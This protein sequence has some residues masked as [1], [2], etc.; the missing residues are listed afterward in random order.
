MRG[1][2]TTKT[3]DSTIDLGEMNMSTTITL[4][5][6]NSSYALDIPTGPVLGFYMARRGREVPSPATAL[7]AGMDVQADIPAG[8]VV[9][10]FNS[11]NQDGVK[12]VKAGGKLYFEPGDRILVPTGLYADI[13][14]GF[15][16][17]VHSRSGTSWKKGLILTNSVGVVDSDYVQE[18]KISL[19]NNSGV[20]L[21]IEDG[22]RI[23]QLVLKQVCNM[24]IKKLNQPPNRKTARNGGFGSTGQ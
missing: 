24:P 15:Y 1:K 12:T 10:Y 6:E 17:A 19:T 2:K 21:Y 9:S 13:P 5:S 7:S 20:R 11:Q 18:I 23:A 14:A 8:E 22:E 4:S 16:L 3:S